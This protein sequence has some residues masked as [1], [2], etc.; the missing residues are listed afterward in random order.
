MPH[1]WSRLVQ[2]AFHLL[3]T[4]F[5]PAYDRVAW[6]VSR[7]DWPAWGRTS[8]AH[9]RPEGRVLELG[10]GPGYLLPHLAAAAPLA[11]GLDRSAAM[12]RLARDRQGTGWLVLG[13]ADALPFAQGAFGTVV[14]TFPA[15]YIAHSLTLQEVYRV[16]DTAGRL[17]I[18][19]GAELTG[20]NLYTAAV[21]LAFALTS[22]P[23]EAS[24]LPGRLQ[25]LGFTLTYHHH[26]TQHG[27]VSVMVAHKT[28]SNP[29]PLGRP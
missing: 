19:D 11:V 22:R 27:R 1:L 10:S 29:E 4:A 13:T 14:S 18:V 21:N 20:R 16:L 8:L 15:P 5:A 3:Y 6:A 9:L 17:V 23:V 12:L 25:A 24:P 26:T 7:G 28:P 2:T